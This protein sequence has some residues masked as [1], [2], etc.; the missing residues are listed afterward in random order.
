MATLLNVK[1]A[2]ISKYENGIVALTDETII[3]VAEIFNVSTDYLL[4][5]VDKRCRNKYDLDND[6]KNHY[7]TIT[8]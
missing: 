4:G 3:K 6:E 5:I 7:L 2:V 8:V 1:R